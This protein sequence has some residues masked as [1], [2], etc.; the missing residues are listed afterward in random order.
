M[1]VAAV[2]AQAPIEE[3][4]EISGTLNKDQ[5]YYFKMTARKDTDGVRVQVK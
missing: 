4:R 2:T 5:H 1:F 3:N